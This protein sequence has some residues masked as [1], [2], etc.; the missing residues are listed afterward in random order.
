MGK[1]NNCKNY[2]K[3]PFCKQCRYTEEK[4]KNYEEVKNERG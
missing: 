1:N 2:G 3:Y 4:C